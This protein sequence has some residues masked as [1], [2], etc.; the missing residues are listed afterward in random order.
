M[1]KIGLL[2][3]THGYIDEKMKSHF[4]ACD[5]VWHAGDFGEGVNEELEKNWKVVRGVYGNIDGQKIRAIIPRTIDSCAKVWMCGLHTLADIP[6]TT[7]RKFEMKFKIIRL[8]YLFAV[9][10]IF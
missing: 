8:H 6:E 10:H 4:S 1:K 2:S 3:D 7:M 9:T 5:E